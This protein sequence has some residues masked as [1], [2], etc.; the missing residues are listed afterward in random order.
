[1]VIKMENEGKYIVMWHLCKKLPRKGFLNQVF[2]KYVKIIKTVVN[3]YDSE[4][5]A[6]YGYNTIKSKSYY[7][8]LLLKVIKE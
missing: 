4:E 1:M 5:I 3:R 6:Q 2:G 7:R 8:P